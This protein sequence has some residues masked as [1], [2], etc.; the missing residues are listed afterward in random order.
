MTTVV[1][2]IETVSLPWLEID[3]M[4]RE[5]L[6]RYAEDH[7]D[8]LRRKKGGSLSPYAGRIVVIGMQNPESAKGVVWFEASGER[9]SRPSAD[10]LFEYIGCDEKTMLTEFWQ[11]VARFDR[12]V[13]FNGRTFDGP[14]L[15]VRSAVHGISPSKNLLGYRYSMDTHVDLLEILTFQGA[16]SRDQV[17]SLHAACV[18]FGIPSPKTEEV[19]GYA[20]GDLY[21]EGRVRQIA[22]Y[23]RKDVEATAALYR[24]LESTLLPLFR[25]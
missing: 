9:T 5:K 17:P 18:A 11:K 21:R 19:H 24:R 15:S 3:P 6:T 25:K 16:V 14:F 10:G 1:F 12:C 20:V 7:E 2:D 4:L 22:D 8:F 23:C 13:T